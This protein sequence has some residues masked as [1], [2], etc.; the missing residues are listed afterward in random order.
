MRVIVLP[1]DRTEA[2][3]IFGIYHTACFQGE[4]AKDH[5]KARAL[6]KIQDILEAVSHA[7][8]LTEEGQSLS[9]RTL[10]DGVTELRM[11]DAYWEVLKERIFG[12]GVPW[13]PAAVRRV[14][15]A[16][17]LLENAEEE[18]PGAKKDEKPAGKKAKARA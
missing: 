3:N 7:E 15:T 11:D 10:N 9:R 1:E 17:D 13:L 5:A 16:F 14:T 12:G 4:G 2:Q 6:G 18:K 8:T